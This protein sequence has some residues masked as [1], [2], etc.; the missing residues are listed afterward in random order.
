MSDEQ[1]RGPLVE[2]LAAWE[3]GRVAA[4]NGKPTPRPK[5]CGGANLRLSRAEA[6]AE[7]QRGVKFDTDPGVMSP[8]GRSTIR[9]RC[10]N[11]VR[12][13]ADGVEYGT[14]QPCADLEARN[15]KYLGAVAEEEQARKQGPRRRGFGEDAA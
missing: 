3:A 15:R 6:W 4:A 1:A 13:D 14:C 2:L 9:T 8:E 12:I 7:V 10:R 11:D 5:H